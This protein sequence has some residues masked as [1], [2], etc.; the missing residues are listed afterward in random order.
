M[1]YF[2]R[3]MT[4]E[5][6]K[7]T[8]KALVK[9]YHPDINPATSLECTE[10][11]KVINAQ[12]EAAVKVAYRAESGENFSQATEDQHVSMVDVLN[13]IVNLPEIEI[14]ICGTWIWVGGNTRPVKDTLMA[15]GFKFSGA[16]K[17][18]YNA[19]VSGK[20]RGKFTMDQ[21]RDKYGSVKVETNKRQRLG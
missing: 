5:Q 17:M 9:T 11:M 14:E 19:P 1:Q 8:Y 20:R 13:H 4:L 18:W 7:V 6:V 10:I 16:K 12:Y 15:N 21:I 3:D 2:T